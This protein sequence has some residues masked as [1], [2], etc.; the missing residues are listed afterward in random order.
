ME[1]RVPGPDDATLPVDAQTASRRDQLGPYRLVRKLGKGGYGEVYEAEHP[2]LGVVALKLLRADGEIEIR[3][4]VREQTLVLD[5]PA[6]PRILDHG[7]ID[8]VSYLAQDLV[9]GA[10]LAAEVGRGA[11]SEVRA[12][13]VL[14]RI[15]EAL[16]YTHARGVVH[17]DLKPL[18]VM[19]S[20]G[21]QVHVL[22]FG[23]ARLRNLPE[24]EKGGAMPGTPAFMAPEQ[25]RGRESDARSDLYA[26]GVVAYYMVSARLPIVAESAVALMAAVVTAEPVPLGRV[27]RDL[28]PAFRDL[29][30]RLLKK[31]PAARPPSAAA[32]AQELGRIGAGE[33]GTGLASLL[34]GAMARCGRLVMVQGA[35]RAAIC[36]Q[37]CQRAEALGM[38]VRQARGRAD[39]GAHA[40]LEELLGAP[41]MPQR[42]SRGQVMAAWRR[43]VTT[44]LRGQGDGER[45]LVAIVEDAQLL[46][47]GSCEVIGSLAS[48]VESLPLL[49]VL[50][51][52]GPVGHLASLA[53]HTGARGQ[54]ATVGD[55]WPCDLRAT[56]DLGVDALLLQGREAR[57]RHA[58]A[59]AEDR[60]Q[61]L[62][63]RVDVAP[64]A[65]RE[66]LLAVAELARL[67]GDRA[68]A[69]ECLDRVEGNGDPGPDTRFRLA[70]ERGL[71]ALASSGSR[72]D[73]VTLAAAEGH[74]LV[75]LEEAEGLGDSRLAGAAKRHLCVAR[76]RE[77]RL[78]EALVDAEEAARLARGGHDEARAL[79]NG[80]LVLWQLGRFGEARDRLE[81]AL[82]LLKMDGDPHD[83][84]VSLLNLGALSGDLGDSPA[85]RRYYEEAL[86]L[87]RELRD[88]GVLVKLLSNLGYRMEEDGEA[89]G[90]IEL[91]L[92][93]LE[94]ARRQGDR[95]FEANLMNGIGLSRQRLGQ[96]EAAHDCFECAIGIWRS[97]EEDRGCGSAICNLGRLEHERGR[98]TE[99]RELFAEAGRLASRLG[100]ARMA[101]HVDLQNGICLAVAGEPRGGEL[102]YS[103]RK[104]A[105]A[106]GVRDVAIDA[107]TELARWLARADPGRARSLAA[108]SVEAARAAGLPALL[109]DALRL[110]ES[111]PP[112]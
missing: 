1:P 64:A 105:G 6:I 39:A 69:A 24:L 99:A 111:I 74:F 79:G 38:A 14:A 53:S 80:A 40:A 28:S 101:V 63:V 112:E 15:A 48:A 92:E 85:A 77:G 13:Q 89:E 8:G 10:D 45:A 43:Q 19:L 68:R 67:R 26:L 18:N 61:T 93:A 5:H 51:A 71:L 50:S 20:D 31:D 23:V 49:L 110:W 72:E 75:A 34:R 83:E 56:V 87:A 60:Y 90:A 94:M 35:D 102:L 81:A 22:D 88:D 3:R 4:F 29:V 30:M 54:L 42:P 78:E 58:R 108:E 96:I 33:R 70:M 9:R 37:L 27:R 52:P 106:L 44:A 91:F 2:L 62:L 82:A 17:R 21:D 73:P 7:E 36:A 16:S 104:R 107:T 97:L 11:F 12:C 100:D 57:R 86:P 98:C 32:V 84:M 76:W 59:L 66:A 109:S 65:R 95:S 41:E 46:D 55:E 103:V 25:A 47:D